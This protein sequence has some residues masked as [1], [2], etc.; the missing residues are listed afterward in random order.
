VLK[1]DEKDMDDIHVAPERRAAGWKP[2]AD[3]YRST[4]FE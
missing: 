1:Y 2:A 3:A 4:P